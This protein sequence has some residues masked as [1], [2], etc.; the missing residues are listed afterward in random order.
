M[1]S[2]GKDR[3][4]SGALKKFNAQFKPLDDRKDGGNE[5]VND[6]VPQNF[7]IF[8]FE[9]WCCSI[10]IALLLASLTYCS[11]CLPQTSMMLDKVA[12][13]LF[14]CWSREMKNY[15]CDYFP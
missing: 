12:G 9:V 11:Y 6:G 15:M 3:L 14:R 7:D 2:D 1:M 10:Q 5:D 4:L 13:I 8:N